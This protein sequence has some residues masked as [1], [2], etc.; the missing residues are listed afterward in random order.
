MADEEDDHEPPV[1]VMPFVVCES[2][3]GPYDDAAFVAGCRFAQID[4]ALQ[5]I[6]QFGVTTYELWVEPAL[7]PQLDLLA[8]HIDWGLT[9]APWEDHPDDWVLASF[10]K[11][12][13]D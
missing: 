2:D 3:G 9:T 4:H 12:A 11:Q 1:L 5:T 6:M 8:M 10:E 13:R 7:V